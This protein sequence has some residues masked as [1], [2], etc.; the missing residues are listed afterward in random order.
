MKISVVELSKAF[1]GKDIF[2]NFSLEVESGMRLCVCGPNGTGKSTLL[3]LM[4][5]VEDADAGRVILPKDCRLGYVE[6][7]LSAESRDSTLLSYVL[8]SVHDWTEFWSEWKKASDAGDHDKLSTLMT[9][10]TELEQAYGYN[11][12]PWARQRTIRGVWAQAD[13]PQ[14]AFPAFWPFSGGSLPVWL[15]SPWP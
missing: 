5:G 12:E 4:A 10:Q 11:P 7:E 2:Q 13:N 14:A 8:D 1:G 9:R 3:R 6:Q 15:L